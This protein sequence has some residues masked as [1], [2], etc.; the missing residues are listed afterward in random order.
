M[1]V[2]I[3]IVLF[4]TLSA[5]FQITI[6]TEGW[7]TERVTVLTILCDTVAFVMRIY[8]PP[9]LCLTKNSYG[10]FTGTDHRS[11]HT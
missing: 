2:V 8:C 5:P 3:V 11:K 6:R 1:I 9:L 10:I 4:L 7:L